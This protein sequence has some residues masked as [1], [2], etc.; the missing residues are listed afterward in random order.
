MPI[1]VGLIVL[2]LG[3]FALKAFVRAPPAVLARLIK[4]G[5][6]FAALAAAGLLVA[7]GRLDMGL[8]L[9]GV[10]LWLLGGGSPMSGFRSNRTSGGVSRVRSA[11]IEM[12]LDH[13]SGAMSGVILAGAGEGRRLEALTR[14]DLMKLYRLCLADDPDGARLL[15]V[16]LDRRLPGWRQ[17]ADGQTDAGGAG[18]GDARR[19]R[20]GS[21]S[22]DEAYEILGLPKGAPA[23][24]IARAHRELMKK[25]HPDHGG[26]TDLAAR[27]NEAKD[28]LMRRRS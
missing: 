19:A 18:P 4:R 23:H 22:E 1:L 17:A 26:T 5:G 6:G 3:V 2:V 28:V 11:M 27:V 14:D 24:E 10:G 7:R 12:E 8:A 9:G 16:Y 25:L 20:P 15:E 13:A 21:V